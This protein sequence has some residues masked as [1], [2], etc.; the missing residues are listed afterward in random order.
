MSEHRSPSEHLSSSNDKYWMGQT[1]GHWTTHHHFNWSNAH[2]ESDAQ[3]Y[4]LVCDF[5]QLSLLQRRHKFKAKLRVLTTHQYSQNTGLCLKPWNVP[6]IMAGFLRKVYSFPWRVVP[7]PQVLPI[8]Y[9]SFELIKCSL[10]ERY[11]V[12]NSVLPTRS[13]NA[14]H[15]LRYTPLIESLSQAD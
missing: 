8:Q 11:S 5:R 15:A 6:F 14:I 10:G 9:F 7:W 4:E 1:C 3:T 2:S 13:D 12:I